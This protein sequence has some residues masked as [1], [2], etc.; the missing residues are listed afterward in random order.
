MFRELSENEAQTFRAWA[1]DNYI[2]LSPILGIWHPVVQ[3]ECRRM[4]E[5][6]QCLDPLFCPDEARDVS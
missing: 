1:R 5:S 2:P 4:N 6:A 3:D